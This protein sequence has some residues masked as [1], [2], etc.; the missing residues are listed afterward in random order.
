ML[1]VNVLKQILFAYCHVF[2]AFID[3]GQFHQRINQICES[4]IN[5]LSV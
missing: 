1:I 3:C 2:S 5:Q 4:L